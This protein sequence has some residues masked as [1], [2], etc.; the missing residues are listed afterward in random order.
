MNEIFTPPTVKID[1]DS[2]PA[3]GRPAGFWIRFV[4]YFIDSIIL[5]IVLFGVILIL[6]LLALPLEAVMDQSIVE[7]IVGLLMLVLMLVTVIGYY[8]V[9]WSKYGTTLGKKLFKLRVVD[10]NTNK[11]VS[12]GKGIGR[13]FSYMISGMPFY[14]GFFWIGWDPDKEGFHDKICQTRVIIED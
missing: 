10:K 6:G 4:A 9:G 14:L 7:G 13:I 3:T 12:L 1:V 8:A 5:N 11:N 2:I